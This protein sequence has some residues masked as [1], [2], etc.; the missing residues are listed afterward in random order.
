MEYRSG[1]AGK[2]VKK[3]RVKSSKRWI[4]LAVILMLIVGLLAAG[5]LFPERGGIKG[6]RTA[7]SRI[8]NTFAFVVLRQKPHFYSLTFEKNAKDYR[9][10]PGDFFE[11]SYRD[12]FVIKEIATDV[13]FGGGVTVDVEGLGGKDDL[14]KLLKGIDLVDKIVLKDRN[15][16]DRNKME[17]FFIQIRYR[18]ELIA[19][20][21]IRV[22][23][24]PQDWLRYAR[25]SGN[26]KV[27][28]EYLKRA[29]AMNRE[30]VNVRKMLASIYQ[31]AGMTGDA[32]AQYM[33]ILALKPKDADVLSELA[34][35]YLKNGQYKE[36]IK[37]TERAVRDNPRDDNALANMA[38]AWE[39]LENLS[40]AIAAYQE[41]LKIRPDNPVVIFRLGGTYEKTK[42]YA[43][44]V[45]LYQPIMWLWRLPTS[46]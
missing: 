43:K 34:K 44:A 32:I 19:S 30:D 38:L 40:K 41:A 27:Q 14:G 36:V 29:L 42:Q 4:V 26:Q 24:T 17:E 37:I 6:L 11:I 5:F 35:C 21:P 13:L 18:E 23:I 33:E 16:P 2:S 20:I 45:E 12:E 28:I 22:Q 8:G 1:K 39:R 25:S 46:T 10:T 7:F 3:K 15:G 31:N 9:L